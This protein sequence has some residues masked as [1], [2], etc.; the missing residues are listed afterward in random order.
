MENMSLPSP[1]TFG[2]PASPSQQSKNPPYW[3]NQNEWA[4]ADVTTYHEQEFDF[5]GNL[6]LFDKKRLF[7]ELQVD[8]MG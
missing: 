2:R 6:E 8:F 7:A 1:P 3:R 4:Q 5:Q